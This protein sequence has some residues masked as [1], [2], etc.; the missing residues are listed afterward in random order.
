[1]KLITGDNHL[2]GFYNFLLPRELFVVLAICGMELQDVVPYRHS[3]LT[4]S[5]TETGRVRLGIIRV[6]FPAFIFNPR[7]NRSY[8]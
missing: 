4:Y 3:D 5:L 8:Y 2:N 1:M 7:R 6:F